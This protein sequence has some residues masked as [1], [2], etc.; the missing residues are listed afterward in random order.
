MTVKELRRALFELPDEAEVHVDAHGLPGVGEVWG[1][2]VGDVTLASKAPN[3]TWGFDN[4]DKA[5]IME[6]WVR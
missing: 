4:D 5:V 3:R 6:V 2:R 1:M